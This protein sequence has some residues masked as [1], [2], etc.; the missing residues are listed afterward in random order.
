M[1]GCSY[2]LS[3]SLLVLFLFG[4][5]KMAYVIFFLALFIQALGGFGG[6][7]FAVPLLTMFYEPRFIVPSFAII[8]C[9]SNLI[10][11]YEVRAKV[12]WE[13]ISIIIIGSFISLPVGVF[14]LKYINQDIIRLLISIVT[15]VLGI[16]FLFGFKP[17][18]RET[19]T[20]FFTAGIISGFLSGTAAMGGPPLIFLMMALGFKKDTFRAVLIGFFVLNGVIGNSLY[21]INGL[22]NPLNLKIVLLGILPSLAGAVLGIRV[23]N[24]LP[25]EKFARVTVILVV[26]IGIIGTARAVSL[27]SG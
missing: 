21:F 15:F 22:F 10:I 14:T 17:K 9:L 5:L 24:T 2:S 20:T 25:E 18:I 16:L 3:S 13:K 27:L 26:L 11:L 7:L 19:R 8:V 1:P 12:R 6:G 4:K 23:K